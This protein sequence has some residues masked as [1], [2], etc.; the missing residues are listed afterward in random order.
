M[1]QRVIAYY[2]QANIGRHY[3]DRHSHVTPTNVSTLAVVYTYK[4]VGEVHAAQ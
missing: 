1:R 4:W 3:D 2:T